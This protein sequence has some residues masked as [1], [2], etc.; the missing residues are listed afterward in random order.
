MKDEKHLNSTKMDQRRKTQD[1]QKKIPVGARFFAPVHTGPG[2]YPA[3]YKMGTGSLSRGL[4]GRS[5]ELTTHPHLVPGL[6]K[7]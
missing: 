3:S 2:A 7:E 5:V 6:K 4:S 1:R